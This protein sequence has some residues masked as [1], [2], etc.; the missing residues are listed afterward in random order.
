MGT[1][2]NK[3]AKLITKHK[4]ETA[5]K[6]CGYNKH[7]EAMDLHHLDPDTKVDDMSTLVKT[8]D[9]WDEVIEEAEKCVVL[10]VNCHREYHA[11]ILDISHLK[12]NKISEQIE[13]EINDVIDNSMWGNRKRQDKILLSSSKNIVEFYTKNG[14]GKTGLEF[15]VNETRLKEHLTE[16]NVYGDYLDYVEDSRNKSRDHVIKLCQEGKTVTEISDA[17]QYSFEWVRK[18]LQ[19]EKLTAKKEEPKKR[20]PS[21]AELQH[22]QRKDSFQDL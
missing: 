8:S 20:S 19:E 9:R 2:I 21:K 18:I 11:K 5:C 16:Q 17:I 13:R 14:L 1:K 15:D 12:P 4:K 3:V 10:C 6:M 7:G 22:A